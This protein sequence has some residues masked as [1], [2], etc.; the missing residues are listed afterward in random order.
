MLNKSMFRK[1]ECVPL[2]GKKRKFYLLGIE[3][4]IADLANMSFHNKHLISLGI[5]SRNYV[6]PKNINSLYNVF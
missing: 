3:L 5:L 6:N 1:P 4:A 2:S